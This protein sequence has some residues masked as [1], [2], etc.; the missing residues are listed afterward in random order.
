MGVELVLGS[1]A[2]NRIR[3]AILQTSVSSIVVSV[4]LTLF[5]RPRAHFEDGVVFHEPGQRATRLCG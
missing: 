3:S 1:A 5:M 2:S 4:F